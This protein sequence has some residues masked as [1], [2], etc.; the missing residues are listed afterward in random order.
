MEA[1]ERVAGRKSW[2]DATIKEVK[3]LCYVDRVL[4]EREP[5]IFG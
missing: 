5:E 1:D 3:V 4:S 2:S